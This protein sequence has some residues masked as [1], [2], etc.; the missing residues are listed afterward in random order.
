M[1]KMLMILVMLLGAYTS[2]SA[3]NWL[4]DFNA[5]KTLATKENKTTL[6]VFQGSDWCT[7]C[8]LLDR[9]IWS[10]DTFKEYAKSHYVMVKADFPRK[11]QNALSEAQ[12]KQ[13]NDLAA[14]YNPNGYFP[15]VVVFD[16]KGNVI[17]QTGFQE[18]TPEEYI[19][20][21]NSFNK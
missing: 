8:I 19:K 21:L 2:V 3:Q 16:S 4:T 5:A 17:G 20:L 9:K 11:K 13:N 15:F 10:T 12:Q 14:K 18:I 7:P 6:L 1:K